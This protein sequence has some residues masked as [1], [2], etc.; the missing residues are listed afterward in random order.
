MKPEAQ[1][2]I[3]QLMAQVE[4]F[5]DEKAR[6]LLLECLHSLLALYGEGLERILQLVGNAGTEGQKLLDTLGRDQLVRALL[7]VHGLHPHSLEKR[8]QGALEKMRPYLQSHGGNVEL[9]S[10]QNDVARLRL[11]G[12]C[13]TCPSSSV[14]LELAVRQAIEAA[15][16]DLAGFEVEGVEPATS[17]TAP[18]LVCDENLLVT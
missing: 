12:T 7:L 5:P 6:A 3:E 9:I 2:R 11:Q 13:K 1:Q 4:S 10:L 16:P 15:C 17:A 14:T 18:V 8:L